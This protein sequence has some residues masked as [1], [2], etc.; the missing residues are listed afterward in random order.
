MRKI[1]FSHVDWR[2]PNAEIVRMT[3]EKLSTVVKKRT[4]IGHPADRVKAMRV[5]VALENLT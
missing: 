5:G 3:G 4:L 1:D 2:K